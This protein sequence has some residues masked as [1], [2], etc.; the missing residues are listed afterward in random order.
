M[1]IFS[2]L[3]ILFNY[4]SD[5]EIKEYVTKVEVLKETEFPNKKVRFEDKQEDA[6]VEA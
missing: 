2:V 6:E 3:V 5:E 4:K 1:F